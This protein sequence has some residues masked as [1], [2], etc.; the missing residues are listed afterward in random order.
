MG[1][2]RYCGKPAGFFRKQH[3]DCARRHEQAAAA[4]DEVCA[5][6]ALRGEGLDALPGRVRELAAA[7]NVALTEGQ[8]ARRLAAAWGNAVESAIEDRSLSGAEKHGLDRFRAHFN[9]SAQELDAEG[10]FSVYRMMVLL[11]A[12][13]DDGVIPRYDRRAARARF[14]PLPFNL[15]KS[16]A[17]L[18]VFTDVG[19][20]QEITR[21]EFRG[22]SLGLSIRVMPGVYVR[23]GQF[24]GKSVETSAMEHVDTGLLGITTK[25]IYFTGGAKSFRVR[26]ERIVSFE[27]YSD[28][29]GIMRDTARAKPE[30][31]MLEAT[32]A[33]LLMNLIDAVLDMDDVT[34]PKSGSPTLD[35]LV[36]ESL[37]EDGA[38]SGILFGA[39]N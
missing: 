15:M 14:G 20:W 33:W 4:I 2:C 10:H 30:V 25:H 24:R 5:A 27:P 3:D 36:D 29:L 17:L 28:G 22:R 39:S 1:D 6:A 38:D 16:E 32:H 9:L 21:R 7:G 11:K 23:P 31:F 35:E 26:L 34:L 19:Y 12:V 18:W 37:P 13:R 8:L